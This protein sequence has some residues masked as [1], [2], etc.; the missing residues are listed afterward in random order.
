[1]DEEYVRESILKPAAKVTA[2]FPNVMPPSA[3]D[4]REIKGVVSYLQSLKEAP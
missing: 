4:E 3:L 1:V 2:G